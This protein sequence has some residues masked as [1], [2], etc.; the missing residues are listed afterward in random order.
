[1]NLDAGG[2][3]QAAINQSTL[4][5]RVKDGWTG[6]PQDPLEIRIFG[7][8][9]Y[10]G[11]NTT[12][13][14]TFT[15][16]GVKAGKQGESAT[17]YSL[18]PSSSFLVKGSD[19]NIAPNPLSCTV[20]KKTGKSVLDL[21]LNDIAAEGLKIMW[22]K[23]DDTSYSNE[24]VEAIE[25]GEINK[26][27][28]F[29]LI[30]RTATTVANDNLYDRETVPL[31]KDGAVGR[32][33]VAKCDY[34]CANACA[35]TSDIGFPPKESIGASPTGWTRNGTWYYDNDIDFHNPQTSND[36]IPIPTE[37]YPYLWK[38]E[39]TWYSDG[40]AFPSNPALV[41]ELGDGIQSIESWYIIMENTDDN[42]QH[43]E[44]T[45]N[46]IAANRLEPSAGGFTL[47]A[48][49]PPRE[50]TAGTEAGE[51]RWQFDRIIFSQKQPLCLGIEIVQEYYMALK[52]VETLRGM[53]GEANV[54]GKE[55]AYL[56]E[57][58]GVMGD[59]DWK[60]GG[61]S[62]TTPDFIDRNVKA[63]LN[64][65][66]YWSETRSGD[67][68]D[69]NGKVKGRVMFAAGVTDLGGRK[70]IL[71][72][73]SGTNQDIIID[74]DNFSATT[75]IWES[76]FLECECAKISG[77]IWANSGA[78]G[79]YGN[80]VITENGL[81]GFK[82]NPS[83]HEL[84]V[85]TEDIDRPGIFGITQTG[86]YM[87]GEVYAEYGQIGCLK[88]TEDGSIKHTGN[89]DDNRIFEI[90][91][92]GEFFSEYDKSEQNY[93]EHRVI[94]SEHIIYNKS[95]TGLALSTSLDDFGL[96]VLKTGGYAAQTDHYTNIRAGEVEI[97]YTD[98]GNN[99]TT[100]FIRQGIVETP[101]AIT[102]YSYSVYGFYQTSDERKKTNIIPLS[103]VLDTIDTIPT[104]Y[105]NWK[106][107]DTKERRIGT[108]A[109]GVLGTYP[110]IVN[111]SEETAY[112]VEYPELSVIAIAAIK[113]LKAEVESLKEEIKKLK[114]DRNG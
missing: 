16:A 52:D 41:C 111:G 25:T 84:I 70:D 92:N 74:I 30:P 67:Y 64:A 17:I 5:V 107:G 103:N 100:T 29:A 39:K 82:V 37:E 68:C 81:E 76:G 42:R 90:N 94:S 2:N 77:E 99:S 21:S 55:G 24:Y 80:V 14:A 87:K 112:T 102:N 85:D 7:A 114:E 56:R 69:P 48:T 72:P 96:D 108:V 9:T 20:V 61:A 98:A 50:L 40:S 12:S 32:G 73:Y 26:A 66:T 71:P 1:M 104:V 36:A 93:S 34:W 22:S 86:L 62:D 54:E 106:E 101:T 11:Q 35:T 63:F 31:V 57:F 44:L 28:R 89:T 75:K 95:R 53:F 45:Y 33:V 113:E 15:L 47:L 4:T 79:K 10:D 65:S 38:W 59:W 6:F 19:G 58:L 23:D 3:I 43:I 46:E 83:T 51:A 97:G 91:S 60:P 88:I 49:T 8:G 13:R 18:L 78:F 27:V 110:E 105:Y 109:Q